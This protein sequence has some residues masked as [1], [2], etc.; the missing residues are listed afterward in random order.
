MRTFHT[1]GVAGE[2]ITHGLPRVTGV[3]RGSTPKGLAPISEATGTVTIEETEKT[4]KIVVT[5][6]TTE[7]T[8]SSNPGSC[9][10]LQR[11]V[12]DGAPHRGGAPSRPPVAN[13][14]PADPDPCVKVA[15]P[16]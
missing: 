15:A 14:D 12:E 13:R 9:R 16:G 6:L 4:R 10:R 8:R 11:E 2:D 1:G 7:R 5:R 3:V